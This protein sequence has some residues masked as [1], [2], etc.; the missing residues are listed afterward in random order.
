MNTQS[1]KDNLG[2]FSPADDARILPTVDRISVTA[3]ISYTGLGPDGSLQELFKSSMKPVKATND[4]EAYGRFK[5]G[6]PFEGAPFIAFSIMVPRDPKSSFSSKDTMHEAEF[7]F[8]CGDVAMYYKE[9]NAFETASLRGKSPILVSP[10][11]SW[12]LG[13]ASCSHT[14][15][16]P[17]ASFGLISPPKL[18]RLVLMV[19]D[20]TSSIM[21]TL[22]R[23][24]S[25]LIRFSF[26][27]I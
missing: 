8:H 21:S 11:A 7:R 10:R 20:Q 24:S 5:C 25:K 6:C 26:T 16:I 12:P 17:A 27:R 9:L 3:A 13:C 22:E 2:D 23:G 19:V 1:Y 4:A 14:K 15:I 18:S